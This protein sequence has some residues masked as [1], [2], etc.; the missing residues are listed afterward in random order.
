MGPYECL[1]GVL[2]GGR[3]QGSVGWLWNLKAKWKINP[4]GREDIEPGL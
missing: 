4:E 2:C 1:I 3:G